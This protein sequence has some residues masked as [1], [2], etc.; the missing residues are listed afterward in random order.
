MQSS[1]PATAMGNKPSCALI[2]LQNI[3]IYN[4]QHCHHAVAAAPSQGGQWHVCN[5]HVDGPKLDPPSFQLSTVT[6]Q[7]VGQHMSLV[8]PE[9]PDVFLQQQTSSSAL[10]HPET[11]TACHAQVVF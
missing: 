5:P 4:G 9:T 7:N 10:G 6:V 1:L 2:H 11:H 3:C 8:A